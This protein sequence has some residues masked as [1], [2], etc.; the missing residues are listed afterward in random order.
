[1]T[2]QAGESA[3]MEISE[4]LK[5]QSDLKIH[6]LE[7][8][9]RLFADQTVQSI[10]IRNIGEWTSLFGELAKR[11]PVLRRHDL[12]YISY[13][14]DRQSGADGP[15]GMNE[16]EDTAQNGGWIDTEEDEPILS[17]NLEFSQRPPDDEETFF[18]Q[19][20]S[21]IVLNL[22]DKDKY[23]QLWASIE[24]KPDIFIERQTET[25]QGVVTRLRIMSE[26]LNY[27][28]GRTS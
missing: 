21:Q 5:S 7:L 3:G 22:Y 8:T 27:A 20:P 6:A 11:F 12:V 23:A 17:I 16:S 18:E 10:T 2:E 19:V 25:R 14:Y 15:N 26:L 24:E 1:M 9:S 13:T 4:L 28:V